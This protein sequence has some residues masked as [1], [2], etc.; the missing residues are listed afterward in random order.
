MYQEDRGCAK[1]L[2]HLVILCC[3]AVYHGEPGTDPRKE[4]NW[5]L[6][7]FQKGTDT[8]SGEHE[9]F[10]QHLFAAVQLQNQT[11]LVAFSGGPTDEAYPNLSEAQSYLNALTD[12]SKKIGYS[13]PQDLEGSLI[14]EDAATDSYQNILFSILLFRRRTGYYPSK[15]TIV[16]QSFKNERFLDLHAKALRW[17]AHRVKVLGMNPPFNKAELESS[18][19]GERSNGYKPWETDLYGTGEKLSSK[20]KIRGWK[21]E[22]TEVLGKGLEPVVQRLLR[23]EGGA[24][25][26][27]EKLPWEGN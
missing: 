4:E 17:P 9:T 21:E 16:T 7:A 27:P 1:S 5:A 18:I 8:K 10:L 20:R 26:F 15:I 11:T 14:L 22:K 6:K 24:D 19:A 3:H 23:Y 13:P 2:T 25:V 12:W